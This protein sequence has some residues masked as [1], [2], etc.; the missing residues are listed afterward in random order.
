VKTQRNFRLAPENHQALDRLAELL[1]ET[2]SEALR[3][4]LPSFALAKCISFAQPAGL[5][6]GAGLR[7]WLEELAAETLRQRML[8][9]R[10][11]PMDPRFMA[12]DPEA[13]FIQWM[14]WR[15]LADK[16]LGMDAFV[17]YESANGRPCEMAL[18]KNPASGLWAV[19]KSDQQ[20][21]ADG[22][23]EPAPRKARR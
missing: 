8:S 11:F 17:M 6:R 10:D 23:V 2:P 13:L 16:A 18:R 12:R 20:F 3:Q 15:Y 9:D 1:N 19:L 14:D 7:Q 21:D 4:A 22:L 5:T